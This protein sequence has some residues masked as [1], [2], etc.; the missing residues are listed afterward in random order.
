MS[1][2]SNDDPQA[3]SM[4]SKKNILMISLIILSISYC[5]SQGCPSSGFPSYY[6]CDDLEQFVIEYPDCTCL[7]STLRLP[8]TSGDLTDYIGLSQIDSIRG[9][10]IC[11]EC[12]LSSLVGLENLTYI[13]GNVTIDEPHGPIENLQG[14]NQLTYIGGS[15]NIWE[16]RDLT[17]TA[18]LDNLAYIGNNIEFRTNNNLVDIV[19]LDNISTLAGN[20]WLEENYLLN[21]LSGFESF[22]A[23]GGYLRIWENT[24]LTSLQGLD[25]LEMIGGDIYIDNSPLL[26]KLDELSTLNSVGGNIILLDNAS[27]TDITG[28]SSI[29]TFSGQ[30]YILDNDILTSL[31]GLNNISA[32]QIEYLALLN[33][34]ELTFCSLDNICQYLNEELGPANI[35]LNSNGCNS[36]SEVKDH[37][38]ALGTNEIDTEYVFDI[39]PNPFTQEAIFETKIQLEKIELH[40]YNSFGSRIKSFTNL[41]GNRLLIKRSHLPNGFYIVKLFQ[42]KK[43]LGT[44]IIV[45]Q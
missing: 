25:N 15:L 24:S 36:E 32:N 42:N 4:N 22:S 6:N 20:L 43:F 10:L 31:E 37:C 2:Y 35:S 14:L 41:S 40:I 18:G 9:T 17:S 44:K 30:I 26:E 19:G 3:R 1:H 5:Y 29:E 11:D 27:L 12:E 23:I 16:T 7:P 39:F 45:V 8:Y 21:D 38:I 13:G 34:D 28:L 33:C